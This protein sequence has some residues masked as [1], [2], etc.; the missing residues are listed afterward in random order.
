MENRSFDHM[1]G[2]MN[3]L[4]P[5]INGVNAS[6]SNPTS[7]TDP[8]S[9]RVFFDSK[10]HF[11]DPN[12][13]H[14]CQAI[15]EQ[16]FSSND[17][18]LN[19]APMNGFAQQAESMEPDMSQSVMNGFDPIMIPVYKTLASEFA[20]FDG[21][22][23]S[24]PSATQPNRLYVHSATS[25]GATRNSPWLLAKGYPQRTIFENLD[26]EG[27]SF[28]IYFQSIPATLFYRNLRKLKYLQKFRPYGL[29]FKS[30]AENR[31]FPS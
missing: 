17:T 13:G 4:N 30:D 16:I 22:F 5:E 8:H 19:P 23:A 7:A 29:W 25:Y 14:S 6:E 24:V 11:V 10:S 28:G 2:W 12:P 3:K 18:S 27:I 26:D 15:R 1:L 21:W 9:P 31:K 20:V